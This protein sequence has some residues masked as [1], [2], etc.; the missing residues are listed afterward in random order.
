[1]WKHICKLFVPSA[2]YLKIYHFPT[3]EDKI[4]IVKITVTL[5]TDLGDYRA[6][7]NW[8][9]VFIFNEAIDIPEVFQLQIRQYS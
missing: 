5:Y 8:P 3:K 9:L 7:C 1:M 2:S 4:D 6:K